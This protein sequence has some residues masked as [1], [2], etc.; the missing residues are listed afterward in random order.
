MPSGF[1]KNF[2]AAIA[3]PHEGC[4]PMSDGEFINPYPGTAPFQ[5]R[6]EDRLIFFGRD[7]EVTRLTD[8]ILS[9]PHVILFA[10]SGLGKS[11]LINAGILEKLRDNSCFPVV[12]RVTHNLDGG[13]LNS[14][15]DR[16]DEETKKHAIVLEGQ[17]D[18]SSLWTY[19][20]GAKFISKDG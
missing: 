5:D 10:R 6:Q 12:A 20:E 11:S 9:E 8:L 4:M 13:P 18:R 19:F 16:I 2:H 15:F 1:L 14:I 17:P 7:R 3:I